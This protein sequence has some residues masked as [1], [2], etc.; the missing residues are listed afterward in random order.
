MWQLVTTSSVLGLRRNSKTLPKAKLAP[1]KGHGHCL[2]ACCQS[3]H[4]SFLNPSK[5]ITPEK[6]TQ[7]INETPWKLQHLQPALVNRMGPTLSWQCPTICLTTNASK[8]EQIWAMKFYLIHHIHLT[9]RQLTPTSSSIGKTLPPQ[10]GSRKC[11][12]RDSRIWRNGFLCYRNK[13][14]YFLLTKCVDCNG[15][16]FN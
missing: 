12:P 9:S 6:Y 13:Q 2:V 8:V 3:D 7:Q 5:T 11:F 15:S 4:Y 1:K 16:C 10:A 14:A